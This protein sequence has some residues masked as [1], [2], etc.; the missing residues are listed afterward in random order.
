MSAKSKCYGH[1][2]EGAL[3]EAA[4]QRLKQGELDVSQL[5]LKDMQALVEELEIHRA[6]LAIQNEEL[7]AAY[8]ELAVTRERYRRLFDEAPVGYLTLD[9][10]GRIVEA[11]GRAGELLA[12]KR[13]E[14][15]GRDLSDFVHATDQD[16]L[17]LHRRALAKGAERQVDELALRMAGGEQR[18]VQMV[19]V[20]EANGEADGPRYRCT[21]VD[22]TELKQ[23]Q[24]ALQEERDRLEER[25]AERTARLKEVWGHREQLLNSLGEGLFALDAAGRFTY[26]NPAAV[27]MFG[28]DSP[29]EVRGLE[30]HGL[31]HFSDTE[32]REDPTNRCPIL[33]VLASGERLK[34][35]EDRFY[36]AD[37]TSFPVVLD[38]SPVRENGQI[39]GVVV[40][41]SGVTDRK[42]ALQQLT[43][44]EH[45]VLQYLGRGLTNKEVAQRLGLSHRT[46]EDHRARIMKKLDVKSL[47]ELVRLA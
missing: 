39:L 17:Y 24:R 8:N 20:P 30:S 22:I 1:R 43:P 26:L 28:F 10:R 38:V 18:F 32:H 25:V 23:T 27:S 15:A 12:A 35:W 16:A 4:R 46:V 45:Q 29:E 42:A 7:Q 6:E 21:L 33:E 5:D 41:F 14:L 13:G 11:N 19:S 9:G 2:S 47:A 37:G 36:R 44:R 34:D 3:R 31:V 40:A